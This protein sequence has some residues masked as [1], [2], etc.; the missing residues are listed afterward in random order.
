MGDGIGY[1]ILSW[2]IQFFSGV[3]GS[4]VTPQDT[5]QKGDQLTV[6]LDLGSN[7]PFVETI[8]TEVKTGWSMETIVQF[9]GPLLQ[10]PTIIVLVFGCSII[11]CAIRVLQIRRM[12]YAA[13]RAASEMHAVETHEATGARFKWQR[14]LESASSDDPQKWRSAILEADHMLNELLDTLGYKGETM[15][16]KMRKADVNAF[17]TIDFAWEAHQV[18]NRISQDASFALDS[19]ETRRVI[20]MYERVFEEFHFISEHEDH[21]DHH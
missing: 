14:V 11:Y 6:A 21:G 16:D 4:W 7:T 10:I 12:E 2:L 13:V 3:G 19:R 15:G 9:W 17:S 1:S 5:L 18:R 20:K 8:L